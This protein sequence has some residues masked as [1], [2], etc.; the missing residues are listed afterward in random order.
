M[1]TSSAITVRQMDGRKDA[2]HAR[3]IGMIT[4]PDVKVR[5]VFAIF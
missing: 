4:A 2:D 1:I 5:I 3:M